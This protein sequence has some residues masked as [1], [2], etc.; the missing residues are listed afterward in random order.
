M[1][2]AAGAGAECSGRR[3]PRQRREPPPVPQGQ[4]RRS[5][6][7]RG[8][9][10]QPAVRPAVR[11]RRE[12]PRRRPC[13]CPAAGAASAGSAGLAAISTGASTG[14]AA[15]ASVGSAGARRSRLGGSRHGLHGHGGRRLDA[16]L[17][18]R[19]GPASRLHDPVCRQCNDCDYAAHNCR[20]HQINS[21]LPPKLLTPVGSS[22][23]VVVPTISICRRE[24]PPGFTFTKR[25]RRNL[26]SAGRSRYRSNELSRLLGVF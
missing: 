17:E 14:S 2:F 6:R 16:R 20:A 4:V 5:A 1:G 22:E 15:A 12:A 24:A 19:R 9:Q 3:Q 13:R 10:Q 21:S 18:C 25:R 8:P 23:V 11:L 7:P 26:L